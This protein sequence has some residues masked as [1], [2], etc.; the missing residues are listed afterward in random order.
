MDNKKDKKSIEF[1]RYRVLAEFRSLMDKPVAFLGLVWL[2]LI[3]IDVVSGLNPFLRTLSHII[4]GI[5]I[6]DFLIGLII[7][8]SR[9]LYLKK[10][11]VTSIA[12]LLPAFGMLRFFRAFRAIRVLRM[13]QYIR[14]LNFL[15]L[16]ASTR[17]SLKAVRKFLKANALGSVIA[18]TIILMLVGAA[19]LEYFE[20]PG[21]ESYAEALWWVSMIMTTIGT[22]YW[23]VTIEGRIVTFILGVYAFSFFGYIAANLASHFIKSDQ[24]GKEK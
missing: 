16:T 23:P 12:V 7:A 6:L 15:R 2:I 14:S 9:L 19:G 18:A 13:S 3:I 1:S 11:W 10:N 20:S 5:F 17:R 21:I 24:T 8:P 22:N 4:W